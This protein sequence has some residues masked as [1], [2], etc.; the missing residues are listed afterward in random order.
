MLPCFTRIKLTIKHRCGLVN[1]WGFSIQKGKMMAVTMAEPPA[2]PNLL[3]IVHCGCNTGCKTMTYS[4]RT[5]SL[6]YTD[7]CKEC[8]WSFLR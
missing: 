1:G 7:F 5:H 6:K 2:P 3:K 4:C 8:L